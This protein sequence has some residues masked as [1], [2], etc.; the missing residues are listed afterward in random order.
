MYNPNEVKR[1]IIKILMDNGSM[2]LKDITKELQKN[3]SNITDNIVSRNMRNVNGVCLFKRVSRGVYTIFDKN[4][5]E[6]YYKIDHSV[7][8]KYRGI[9]KRIPI[10]YRDYYTIF[11]SLASFFIILDHY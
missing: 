2:N 1:L 9:I 5:A 10:I 6:K 8:L 4:Y 11:H 3:D 7:K